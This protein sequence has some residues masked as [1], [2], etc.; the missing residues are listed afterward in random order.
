MELQTTGERQVGSSLDDIRLDHRAR[1]NLASQWLSETDDVLDAGC[2]VGYGSFILAGK[3]ATVHGIDIDPDTITFAQK[4]W[5]HDRV[6]FQCTDICTE[7]LPTDKAFTFAT[8]F[9]VIEH[10]VAPELFLKS[11]SNVLA[12]DATVVLSVPNEDAIAHTVELNPFHMRHYTAQDFTD[13]IERTGYQVEEIFSQD[14]DT[15]TKG[16]SGQTLIARCRHTSG[17]LDITSSEWGAAVSVSNR[18]IIDRANTIRSLQKTVRHLERHAANQDRTIAGLETKI[19]TIRKKAQ[20]FHG[21]ETAAQKEARTLSSTIRATE[22]KLATS[23]S[24]LAALRDVQG[25]TETALF[26]ATS[27]LNL[28]NDQ[29]QGLKKDLSLFRPKRPSLHWLAKTLFRNRFF[30]RPV[31]LAFV[32]SIEDLVN[33]DIKPFLR[34]LVGAR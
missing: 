18:K 27:L 7:D 34:K 25:E 3:S 26:K 10:L 13:L 22:K 12:P 31:F 19:L 11:L 1:Y 28:Q 21:R 5:L 2:G 32:N 15:P 30:A 6:T 29:I 20:D 9:E 33:K 4:N 16:T 17:H 23:E 24:S 8:A 14:D